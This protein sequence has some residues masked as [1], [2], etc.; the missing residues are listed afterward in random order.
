ML[1]FGEHLKLAK[2]VVAHRDHSI[3]ILST[4]HD[5]CGVTLQIR[6]RKADFS[7]SRSDAQ[8]TTSTVERVM[9]R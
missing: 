2:Q 5:I 3:Q 6:L 1:S 4:Y 9:N 8:H 7:L